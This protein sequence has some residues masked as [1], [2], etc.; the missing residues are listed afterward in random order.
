MK[1]D[2]SAKIYSRSE[3]PDQVNDW[4]RQGQRIILANGCFD[5]LHVGHVRYLHGAKALGGKL[6]VA[7]NSDASVRRFKGPSRPV[8]EERERAC[9]EEVAGMG[10]E[11]QVYAEGV[12]NVCKF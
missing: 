12:L 6:I 4:R 2:H 8:I 9:D 10:S 5:L 3:L 1:L 7:L 11:P